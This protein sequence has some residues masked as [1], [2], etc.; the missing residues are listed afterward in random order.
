MDCEGFG[1][2]EV[3]FEWIWMDSYVLHEFAWIYID[4]VQTAMIYELR[5]SR[6]VPGC[7]RVSKSVCVVPVSK[8]AGLR[9]SL[10]CI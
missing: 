4:L 2:I 5:F 9:I 1:W 10:N 6:P 8:T 3:A 7:A